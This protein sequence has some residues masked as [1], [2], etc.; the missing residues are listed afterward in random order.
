MCD[1]AEAT[2]DLFLRSSALLEISALLISFLYAEVVSRSDQ[3][4]TFEEME[5]IRSLFR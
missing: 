4:W 3:L 5:G 2:S 1:D